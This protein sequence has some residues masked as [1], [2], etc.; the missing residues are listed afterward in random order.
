MRSEGLQDVIDFCLDHAPAAPLRRRVLLYR[1]LAAIC[2][3]KQD[4]AKLLEAASELER[5]DS[6]CRSVSHSLRQP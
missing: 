2:V 4:T 6:I 3:D 5:A 1:G